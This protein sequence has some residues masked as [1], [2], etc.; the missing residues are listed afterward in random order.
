MS[1]PIRIAAVSLAVLV[2]LLALI[3]FVATEG[4]EVAVLSTRGPDGAERTTRV[5]VVDAEGATWLEA[6]NPER[7]FYA[8]LQ[9]NP[10]VTLERGGE[11]R[12]YLATTFPGS[13]GNRKIRG[14]LREKYGWADWWLQNVVD[15][16]QSIAVRLE[17][18][19]RFMA[20]RR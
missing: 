6:A 12:P 15:T 11:S 20:P 4:P 16:S 9:R 13:E 10:T 5:W 19:T 8:D 17:Q 3:T 18:P 1:A 14:L 2:T 7:G